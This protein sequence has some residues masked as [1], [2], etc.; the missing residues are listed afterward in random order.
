MK[1]ITSGVYALPLEFQYLDVTQTIYLTVVESDSGF[2]LID[3]G[4]PD[5]V[6]LVEDALNESGFYLRNLDMIMITHQDIDHAGA[7]KGIEKRSDVPVL[8]HKADVPYI[9]GD[10]EL[11]KA[12]MAE[13]ASSDFDLAYPAVNVDVELVDNVVINTSAGSMQVVATPGHTPGHISLYIPEQKLLI[14]GDAI[15]G[16]PDFDG[17]NVEATPDMDTAIKS[18]G[19]LAELDVE[20]TLCFHGGLIKHGSDK[21]EKIHRALKQ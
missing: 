18:I 3:T 15:T 1:E 14:A 16:E 12:S 21:I 2:I 9:S 19:K 17:P 20:Q 4:S 6:D 10:K 8:A 13:E 5:H 11:I 7:L